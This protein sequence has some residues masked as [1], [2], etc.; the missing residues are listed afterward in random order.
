MKTEIAFFDRQSPRAGS[1]WL[2]ASCLGTGRSALL[3]NL[4]LRLTKSLREEGSKGRSIYWCGEVARTEWEQK[5]SL[6]D[7]EWR[8]LGIEHVLDTW[9]SMYSPTMG[10]SEVL[11]GAEIVIVDPLDSIL[12]A[13]MELNRLDE[14]LMKLKFLAARNSCFVIVSLSLPYS[15]ELAVNDADFLRQFRSRACINVPDVI[16][17]PTR[18]LPKEMFIRVL[19]GVDGIGL[20]QPPDLFE[21]H[22]DQLVQ[23]LL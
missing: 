16:L 18:R 9:P 1:L 22:G 4:S 19:K 3:R 21:L 15:E 8:R 11:A 2:V 13:G 7:S 10:L 6:L 12:G 14:H 17:V 20:G 5:M 23:P